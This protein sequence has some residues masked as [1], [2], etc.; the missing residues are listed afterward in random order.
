VSDQSVIRETHFDTPGP[1]FKF[2]RLLSGGTETLKM[3]IF[4]FL[5]NSHEP[6]CSTG[7]RPKYVLHRWLRLCAVK[8]GFVARRKQYYHFFFVEEGKSGKEMV[9]RTK[10]TRTGKEMQAE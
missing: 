1:S 4:T 9:E 8:E 6:L 3:S 10:I 5:Q 2:R 7:I